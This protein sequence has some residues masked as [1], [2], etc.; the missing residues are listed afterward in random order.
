MNQTKENLIAAA[1]AAPAGTI[2]EVQSQHSG[3]WGPWYHNAKYVK[4][5]TR[6][7]A[8]VK[9]SA[10]GHHRYIADMPTISE[11]RYENIRKL[12][13]RQAALRALHDPVNL[14]I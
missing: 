1:L 5:E 12:K 3:D 10:Y 2:I 14:E 8:Y 11:I 9:G 6:K 7:F 4:R 13:V